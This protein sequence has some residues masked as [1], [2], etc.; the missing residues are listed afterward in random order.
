MNKMDLPIDEYN[1]QFVEYL[2]GK[3]S[4]LQ[5]RTCDCCSRYFVGVCICN[6]RGRIILLK[7]TDIINTYE[8]PPAQIPLYNQSQFYS[9]LFFFALDSLHAAVM[10]YKDLLKNYND[11]ETI[12]KKA[13]EQNAIDQA[14]S[15]NWF[16]TIY[17]NELTRRR[18][19][20]YPS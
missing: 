4:V 13:I 14:N 3:P 10:S 15:A 12:Y 18:T 1:C 16:A 8:K 5:M 2:K 17:Y 6:N 11:F 19:G 20:N 7:I 9:N